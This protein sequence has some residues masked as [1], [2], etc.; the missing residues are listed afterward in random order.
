MKQENKNFLINI[1]YQALLMAFPL[2]TVPY[3]S[4]VLGAESIGTYSYTYS[5]VNLFMLA[6]MLGISNH[7]NRSVARVRDDREK[8]SATFSSIYTIQ[9]ILCGLCLIGYVAYALLFSGPYAQIALLQLPFLL[10]VC[11]DISWL[12]FGMEQFLFPLT[13]NLAIKVASLVLMVLM[14]KS[15]EDLWIYTAIMSGSTLVSNAFLAVIAPRYVS[16]RKPV[17]SDLRPH[18][19]PIVVLFV[20][21]LAF[22]IYHVMDKTMLGAFGSMLELGFFENAEK[23]TNLPSAVITALGTV[24]L[25]RMSFIM[26]DASADYRTPIM[27]SMKLAM[28]LGACMSAGLLLIADDAAVVLFGSGFERCG[29]LIRVLGIAVIATAWSNVLRT[30]YLIP[31]GLDGVYVRST[32]GAGVINL[33]INLA[34]IP[35]L[36]ALGTCIGTVVAEYFIALYQTIATSKQLDVKVYCRDLASALAKACAI[37]LICYFA[38][39]NISGAAVRLIGEMALFIFLAALFFFRYIKD[40]F[41]GASKGGG[42]QCI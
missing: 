29:I 39:R 35:T 34:L 21:V 31:K 26:K 19:K 11:F 24:M 4:R 32:F 27:S 7:G 28:T 10:S 40:D 18:L 38:C 33:G 20:P 42:K 5:I 23:I 9:L 14:V 41:F 25:P 1:G 6:G 22:S 30:Q 2:I 12:F 8:L 36:G 13:R 15:P 16:Y 17:A 37:A 3:T